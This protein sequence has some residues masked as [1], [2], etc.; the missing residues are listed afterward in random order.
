MPLLLIPALGFP[1]P[2]VSLVGNSIN[3]P[4]GRISYSAVT[5]GKTDS[6]QREME[7]VGFHSTPLCR[8]NA[9]FVLFRLSSQNFHFLVYS[10]VT[11]CLAK[12]L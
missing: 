1:V 3:E 5:T 10:L 7:I 8:E 11:I 2:E 6:Q 9:A 4:P 12:G